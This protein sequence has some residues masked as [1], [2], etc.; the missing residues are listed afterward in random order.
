MFV[1]IYQSSV[2]FFIAFAS[3]LGYFGIFTLMTI[4]SSFIPFPSEVV[5][6]PAGVLISQGKMSFLLIFFV[7]VT[8]S[9]TGALVNYALGRHLGR[10][11]VKY[12]VK[13][14]GK[15]FFISEKN[16]LKSEKYFEKH[17]EITTFIGRLIPGIRQLISL[18][19]GFSK[20]N[21]GKFVFYT[22]AGAGIWTIVLILVGYL[23]RENMTF[24]EQNLG[25]VSLIVGGFV[26][27]I[28]LSY[29]KFMQKN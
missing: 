27:I 1:E 13:K 12:F 11:I 3:S 10:K 18:P 23:F 25:L 21:L 22:G 28:I 19:A 24:V 4:E 15:I 17:G 9:I 14:Y 5:L 26:L 20:M 8:G 7:S 16:V 29:L 6:I 2:D